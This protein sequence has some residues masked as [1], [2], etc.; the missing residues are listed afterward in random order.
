MKRL[1]SA[2]KAV[3]TV[4]LAGLL[5]LTSTACSN[6]GTTQARTTAGD[7]SPNVPGQVQ[8]YEGGMNNFRDVD[9]TRQST[10]GPDAKAKALVDNARRNI[11][12]K[13]IDSVDQYV[14][15]YRTGTPLGE[16][17]RRVGQD[18]RRGA[19]N[20]T[21][22]AQNI[23][24]KGSK[25]LQRNL[26]RTPGEVSKTV[27]EAGQNAKNAGRGFTEGVKDIGDKAG[28]VG[29]RAGEYS[30]DAVDNAARSTNRAIDKAA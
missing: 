4:V 12:E 9:P 13:G 11:N 8:P 6:A 19:E 27:D 10:S 24:D 3:L 16:R 17:T 20:I 7:R 21:E 26:E 15:N 28:K 29:Q 25:N 30:S 5:V 14:E 2:M 22:D 1:F 23:G 18:I